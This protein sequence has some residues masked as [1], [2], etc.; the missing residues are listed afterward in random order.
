MKK[1][2]LYI[3]IPIISNGQYVIVNDINIKGNYTTKPFVIQRELTFK[4]GD[5]LYDITKHIQ[6][7]QQNLL[8]T[9]LFNFAEID[10]IKVSD[11]YYNIIINLTERWYLW[12][13][14]IFEQASRNIN[15]WIYEKDYNKYNYGLFIAKAN[16]RGRNEL[17]RAIARFGFREMYGFAYSIPYFLNNKNL[18]V[19]FK[20]LYYRQK[21]LP[22]KNVNNKPILVAS[23]EYLYMNYLFN[24]ELNY[25][26]KFFSF[27]T[28]NIAYSFEYITDSLF[29]LNP[30]FLID[31]L[32]K[33]KYITMSYSF[34]HDLTNSV[35]YP[36]RGYVLE[37]EIE[38]NKSLDKNLIIPIIN[39]NTAYYYKITP[40]LFNAHSINS[41]Y[42]FNYK[43]SYILNKAF[44]YQT[45]PRGYELYLIDGYAYFLLQNSIRYML[46][47]PH[48]KNIYKL[49]NERFAKIHYAF[50]LSLNGDLGYVINKF[51]EPLTNQWLYG[52]GIGLD[53]VTYYDLTLQTE[54]SIN[55]FGKKG[56]YFHISKNI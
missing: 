34:R 18:G 50:Y 56:L 44:G 48:I 16:F 10:T 29:K 12:P 51:N 36:T 5:T 37:T 46:V 39:L 52:Y 23:S 55:K 3:L 8:K 40:R 42:S 25:R 26:P 22:Y 27:H 28:F 30:N 21:H 19:E 14:P 47:K 13:I 49:K 2:F 32:S 7:S 33:I 53:F 45:S 9:S 43:N 17:I 35:S 4:K 15:T 1:T 6:L 38:L 11:K 24:F 41:K 31:S 20:S 54:F